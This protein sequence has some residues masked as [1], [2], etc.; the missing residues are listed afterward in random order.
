[1]R[2]KPAALVPDAGSP[3]R[4]E[5][6]PPLLDAAGQ[7]LP[8]TDER[9]SNDSP[10]FRRRLELLVDAI[11]EDDPELAAPAFFPRIAYAQVKAIK[12]PEQDWQRRLVRAY[13]RSIHRYH[14]ALGQSAKGL[15]FVGLEI[16]PSRVKLMAPHSEGN[17]LPYYRALH[18]RLLV[19]KADGSRTHFDITSLISWRGEWY[20]VHLHGFD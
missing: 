8:Q 20:V 19:E 15:R 1:M 18:A 4:V 3:E 9:P 10:S 13:E 17:R 6:V 7:P 16:D 14:G 11:A 12:K 5:P 2:S